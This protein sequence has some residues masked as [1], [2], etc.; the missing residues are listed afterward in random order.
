MTLTL[1]SLAFGPFDEELLAPSVAAAVRAVPS[2]AA[3]AHTVAIDPDLADT[4]ALMA[5]FDL[6][7]EVSA[8]CV[9]VLGKRGGEHRHAACVVLANTRADVNGLVRR[10]IDVRK[11]SFAP[12]DWT[13]D[14]TAMEYGGITPVGLPADWPILVDRAVTEQPWVL[15]G[16]GLRRSK[17]A[18]PGASLADLPGAQVL[19]GLGLA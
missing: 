12:Q 9:I 15:I 14:E 8:N 19:E 17:L 11:C 6:P 5:E 13:V 7:A 4:A 16:S 10:T 2:I 18:V 1:G 3:G